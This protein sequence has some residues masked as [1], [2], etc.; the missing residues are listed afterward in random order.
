MSSQ[1]GDAASSLMDISVDR[2]DLLKELS[3][4]QSVIERKSTV[5]ILSN[6]LFEAANGN[7]MISASD[8]ELSL[9]TF[10]PAKVSSPGCCTVP[11]R[12]L[13]EYI[14][15]L[16]G[17][18]LTLRSLANDWVQL[19]AGKSLTKLAGLPYKNFPRL[20]LY[21]SKAAV[22]LPAPI[23][24]A[25]I[26][27]T[28]FAICQEESRYTLNGALL[29]VQ[30]T[31]ITMVTTDGNRLAHVQAST[32][33]EGL[34]TPEMRVLIPKKALSEIGRLVS[35]GEV[36]MLEF[37]KDTSTLYFRIGRRLLTCRQLAGSF[38]NYE[39]I[40]P[41]EYK[42]SVI[43]P[44]AEAFQAIQ[45]VSQLC[46]DTS[47]AV[48]VRLQ[49]SQFCLSSNSPSIGEAEEILNTEYSGEALSS[50]FNP[51]FLME[52]LKAAN[53]DNVEFHF[54]DSTSATELR[55]VKPAGADGNY[56]YIVM[57]IRT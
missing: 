33:V 20:P 50:A 15:L 8:L 55:P 32:L 2:V 48:K 45:R 57:P 23:F 28:F 25:L 30:P 21:P 1:G 53:T 7:L 54:K 22:K 41:R 31:M 38:P 19:R 35:L 46:D 29:I 47:A 34:A 37:A 43:L 24:R 13:R 27:K 39:S 9:R 3:I 44:S 56:R 10:C 17:E 52:F 5:P 18:R 14:R 42:R 12:K 26:S 51:R 16:D 11:G 36:E 49:T 4:T 6:F 40:L